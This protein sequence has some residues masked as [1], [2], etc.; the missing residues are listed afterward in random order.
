MLDLFSS[1]RVAIFL[2]RSPR[3]PPGWGAVV[4]P[5]LMVEEHAWGA[6]VLPKLM[7]EEHAW[8]AVVLPKLMVEEHAWGALEPMSP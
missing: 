8:G 3:L 6:V 7:V 1:R 2:A 5:N 4:L